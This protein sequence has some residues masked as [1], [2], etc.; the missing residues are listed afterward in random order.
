MT[1]LDSYSD[2]ELVVLIEATYGAIAIHDEA[3]DVD[4]AHDARCTLC[5]LVA[6]LESR[7]AA[8]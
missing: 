2:A 8:A 6:E 1:Q 4:K 3:H 5:R 7:D